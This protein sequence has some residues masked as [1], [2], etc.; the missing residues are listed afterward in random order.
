M[1]SHPELPFHKLGNNGFPSRV[2]HSFGNNDFP[3]IGFLRHT[4]AAHWT[5][6][7]TPRL[8]ERHWGPTEAVL[9]GGPQ[10][11]SRHASCE[12]MWSRPTPKGTRG[13]REGDPRGA[14]DPAPYPGG[15]AN[16][17]GLVTSTSLCH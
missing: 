7:L 11:S 6:P 10:Q 3:F 17:W 9:G 15:D 4:A 1:V 14:W 8:Q 5:H 13:R 16:Q 12:P 2:C